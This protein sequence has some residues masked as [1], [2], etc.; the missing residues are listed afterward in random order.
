M[1]GPC[2]GSLLPP[3]LHAG[4]KGAM[5]RSALILYGPWSHEER[6][7]V[8]WRALLGEDVGALGVV[9][10]AR[11]HRG[12]GIGLGLVARGSEI[13]KARGARVGL[14]VWVVLLEFYAK[15]GYSPWRSYEM[16]EPRP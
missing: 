5:A 11:E 13:L 8:R 2:A 16:A 10:V 1:R 14:I 7:D 6:S 15:L 9:G 4:V 3:S 12:R